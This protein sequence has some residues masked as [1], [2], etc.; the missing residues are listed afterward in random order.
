MKPLFLPPARAERYLRDNDWCSTFYPPPENDD[1]I[2]YQ[3]S[4]RNVHV[5]LLRLKQTNDFTWTSLSQFKEQSAAIL[6]TTV[7]SEFTQLGLTAAY[8]I[9]DRINIDA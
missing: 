3:L 7:E 1:F 2:K 9:T 4:K 6:R 8:F 5:G